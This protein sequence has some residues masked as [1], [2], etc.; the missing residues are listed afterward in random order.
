EQRFAGHFGS[1]AAFNW[2]VTAAQAQQA[3]Q[4]FLTER[5]PL[6]GRYQDAMLAGSD[7][8]FHALLSPALNLGLLD[9][10]ELC[11]RAEAEWRAGRA[12]I[13][14]VEGF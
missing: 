13:E 12:P 8:M 2:P 5:L 11:R 1:T 9:P 6:F 3:A 14:A 4:A 10:L 7:T